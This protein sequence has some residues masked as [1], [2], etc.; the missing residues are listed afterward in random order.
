MVTDCQTATDQVAF[1]LE[2]RGLIQPAPLLNG[3][4]MIPN[5][6]TKGAAKPE[7]AKAQFIHATLATMNDNPAPIASPDPLS[8]RRRA[9]DMAAEIEALM[10]GADANGRGRL[11]GLLEC[12]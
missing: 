1:M 3:A 11:A 10:R 8:P 6:N 7:R 5:R 4:T 12:A 2:Q 9:E